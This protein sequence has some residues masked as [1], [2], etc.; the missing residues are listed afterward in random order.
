MTIKKLMNE[1]EAY[2]ARQIEF[3]DLET[4]VYTAMAAISLIEKLEVYK[5][6][7]VKRAHID[8]H[9]LGYARKL[10]L[11]HPIKVM[12]DR[13]KNSKFITIVS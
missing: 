9:A 2:N 1:R 13:V 5:T 12:K 11:T 3:L 8:F 10:G 4:F 6:I 7:R